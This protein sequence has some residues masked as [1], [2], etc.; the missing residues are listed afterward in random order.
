M[1]NKYLTVTALN[2]YI[3]YKFETDNALRNVYVK[4]EISN[5]RISNGHLYFSLKDENSEIKAIMF[6]SNANRLKFMPI[7]GMSV[8]VN[9]Q[10][11]LYQKGG[12]YNLNVND[13]HEVGLGEQYLNF[14]RLKEKLDKEGL[15]DPDKKLPIPEFPE[16]VGVI[17]SATGDAINDIVS[18]IQKRFPLIKIYLYPALVQGA[19][20]PRSLIRALQRANFDRIVDVIIIGRGGGS[21]EDLSCFNDE[22]LAREIFNSKIPTVSGVGHEADFTIADFVASRRAPTPTGAAV[23]VSKDQYLIAKEINEK[24]KLIN[25]YYKKTLERKFYEY[26]NIISK[27]Y[28][29]NFLDIINL[30]EKEL[31]RLNYNLTVHSPM[32]YI[33]KSLTKVEDLILRL[34]IYNIEE[35]IDN[36]LELIDNKISSLNYYYKQIIKAKEI[37][38]ENYLDKMIAINPLNL[39]KKGYTLTYQN[40]KLITRVEDVNLEDKVKI[41]FYDGDL[42]VQ[43]LQKNKKK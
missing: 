6:G 4:G 40:S 34:N 17:T 32:N 43:P 18:T 9:A 41:I 28:F 15:F 19:D 5:L 20:A 33:N 1:E 25:F 37:K 12:T 7:D 11:S 26:Q 30:K 22:L 35:K 29:K 39:I 8:L 13:M 3:G 14:L 16:K 10:V 23:V 24:F 21:F 31:E 27:H 38:Y 36:K 42:E 2:K